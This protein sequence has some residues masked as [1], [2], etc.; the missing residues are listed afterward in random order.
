[1]RSAAA[2]ALSQ[3]M[4]A[5]MVLTAS[6]NARAEDQAERIAFFESKIRPVLVEQCL[7]CHSAE[8]G[9]VKGGLRL[10]SAEAMLRGGDGGPAVVPGDAEG[11]LLVE[12]IRYDSYLQMP[13]SGKLPDAT[14][15]AFERW[16]AAGAPDPRIEGEPAPP[17]RPLGQL[18]D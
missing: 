9:K 17:G 3:A 4:I 14:I 5:A 8:A 7:A 12:A 1:M 10:D 2:S 6:P 13:P 15:A 11:S 18:D 16:I